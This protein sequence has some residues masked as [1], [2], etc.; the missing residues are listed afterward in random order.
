MKFIHPFEFQD[1][2]KSDFLFTL[3]VNACEMEEESIGI[4]CQVSML[5]LKK[6]VR[7][8]APKVMAVYNETG[9]YTSLSIQLSEFENPNH[10][11]QVLF[12]TGGL[13][14]M[15]QETPQIGL[16]PMSLKLCSAYI[17]DW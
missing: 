4:P 9:D 3:V 10:G 5:N 11:I 2:L 16:D 8:R 12:V 7:N 1:L 6:A 14:A 13:S 15:R 17:I